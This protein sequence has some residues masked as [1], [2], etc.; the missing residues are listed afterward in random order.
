MNKGRKSPILFDY[1]Y[2]IVNES[3][4]HLLLNKTSTY[5]REA[6]ITH[7]EVVRNSAIMKQGYIMINGQQIQYYR[8]WSILI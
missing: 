4:T 7:I 2:V 8:S 5:H 1:R 3:R 6:G